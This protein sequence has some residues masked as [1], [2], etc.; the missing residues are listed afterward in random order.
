NASPPAPPEQ[1][2][3]LYTAS[4]PPQV[5]LIPEVFELPFVRA[6]MIAGVGGVFS[7]RSCARFWAMLAQGG[8]LDGVRLL[9]EDLVATFNAQRENSSEPDPV[10]F[11]AP[12]PLGI[13]GFWLGA[14][15]PFAWAAKH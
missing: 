4:M 6:A 1:M 7:A 12:V 5:D 14:D 10:M 9:S 2:P 11:N 15:Q 3:P 13:A 8:E